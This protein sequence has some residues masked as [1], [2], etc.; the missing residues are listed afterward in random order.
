MIDQR[1]KDHSDFKARME[2]ELNKLRNAGGVDWAGQAVM[3]ARG[4][5]EKGIIIAGAMMR[6]AAQNGW[7]K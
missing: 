5:I 2:A 1:E 4:L 6:Y 7:G 3:L